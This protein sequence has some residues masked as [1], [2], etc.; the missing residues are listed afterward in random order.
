MKNPG[1]NII[2][3]FREGNTTAFRSVYDKYH[4]ALFYFVRQLTGDSD[5]AEDIVA[6]T[7]VKL[8]NLR[9]KFETENNIKAFLYIAARNASFN[10]L[11]SQKKLDQDHKELVYLNSNTNDEPVLR[12]EVPVETQ[13]LEMIQETL[14]ILPLKQR[15]V[16][17]MILF[18]GLSVE[19]V[20][21]R[22][23]KSPKTIH[24]LKS[25]AINFLRG[26][27]DRKKLAPAI[28]LFYFSL[29]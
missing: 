20:A 16:L 15:E 26:N 24:N 12:N 25:I 22:L 8:W 9:A 29:I 10:F 21:I 6:E 2:V 3:E 18:E 19:E 11:R 14:E 28:M 13:L 17:E 4:R 1:W 27:L 5:E 23:N 7:F